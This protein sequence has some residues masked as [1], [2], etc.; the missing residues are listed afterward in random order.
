MAVNIGPRIGIEGEETYRKDLL[1][2]IQT[3]KTYDATMKSLEASFSSTDSNMSKAA[4]RSSVLTKEV[5][6][7]A[8]RVKELEKAVEESGKKFGET[9]TKTLKWKESLEVAKTKLEELK[10]SLANNNALKAFGDDMQAAGEKMTSIGRGMK[11]AGQT[12]TRTVTAPIMGI[13]AYAVKQAADFDSGMSKVQAISGVTADEMQVL[14][15]K[16]MEMGAATKFTTTEAADALSY[17]AMAGWKT[18]QM[19]GG[20]PGV[21]YLAGASG[22]DLAT[23]S[24]IVTDAMTA[25]NM[26]AGQSQK[27]MRN[28]VEV[29]LENTSRF[30]DVLAAASSNANTNVSMMGESFKYVAPVAGTMGYSIEDTA[31]ALG[32]MANSGIKAS[33]A[34]TTLRTLLTRMAKPTK[35]SAAA[36]QDLG[37]RLDDGQGGMKSFMQVM[38]ELREGFGGLME[39]PEEFGAALQALDE[40]LEAGVISNKEYES[41]VEDLV[42]KTFGAEQAEKARTAAMLAGQRGMAGLL[43]IVSASDEDFEKLTKAIQNSEGAATDMYN[44]MQNNLSG[45]VEKLKSQTQVLAQTMGEELVPYLTDGVKWL[46]D[47]VA[48]F[49]ALEPEEKKQIIKIA[50][51]AAAAGPLLSIVGQATIGIGAL[52]I[53]VG[54]LASGL[55][56]LLGTQAAT[57]VAMTAGGTA[58]AGAAT[59]TGVFGGVLGA[60]PFAAVGVGLAGFVG[61]MLAYKESLREATPVTDELKGK[62]AEFDEA[63]AASQASFGSLMEGISSTSA[64][65]N[66]T[67]TG[68]LQV[69][70]DQLG[71]CVT[72]EGQV[73]AGAEEAANYI[74]NN[75]NQAL[76]TDFAVSADGFVTNAQGVVQ[77]LADI[78]TSIDAMVTKMQ[79][80]SLTSAISGD[81]TAALQEQQT[82]TANAETATANYS[83]ALDNLIAQQQKFNEARAQWQA[84]IDADPEAGAS[85]TATNILDNQRQALEEAKL[86]YEEAKT[87]MTEAA[88]QMAAAD[89]AVKLLDESMKLLAEGTPESVEMVKTAYGEIPGKVSE[90]NAQISEDMAAALEQLK[91]DMLAGGEQGGDNLANG[92]SSKRDKSQTAG[93][94]LSKAAAKGAENGKKDM[95]SAANAVVD[96]F[97]NTIRNRRHEVETEMA[98]LANA[99]TDASAGALKTG[100]P[101]RVMEQQGFWT[102]QG[103]VNGIRRNLHEVAR[104]GAAIGNAAI[105]PA[106][107]S[108]VA[109]NDTRNVQL[110][111]LLDAVKDG[112]HMQNNVSVQL[113]GDAEKLFRVQQKKGWEYIRRTGS[114]VYE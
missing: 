49:Q 67:G 71:E 15:D 80:Q 101:S 12:L 51:I 46:Q 73:K 5:T 31:V 82:A 32:L 50:A 98:A 99:G 60:L 87:Q 93:N 41:S 59:S 106:E 113:T 76:G 92:I 22:E 47:M 112:V 38:E 72:A 91:T 66:A 35:E 27:V 102:V 74:L 97:I 61:G 94:D 89:E 77:S 96:G 48:K 105:F 57:N 111:E 33:Q 25:F 6:A 7:Q 114:E 45:E 81:Y 86:V 14:R 39:P 107:T 95:E 37:I 28:G 79:Q 36:M 4:Q 56:L 69:W 110:S 83:T 65:I 11:S 3:T 100:S 18:E 1:N 44:T 20:L 26:V 85:I 104:A 63:L 53:G 70:V 78:N 42:N 43:A 9:D 52:T 40:D 21:M 13:G 54:K 19:V 24:D 29:E 30:V 103:Y 2:L 8:K 109:S 17:M 62:L 55:G 84:E 10:T 16:A 88:A 108:G 64:N 34:G 68:P 75:L 58:A 90:V 23:T